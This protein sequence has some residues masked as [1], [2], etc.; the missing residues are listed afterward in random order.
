LEKTSEIMKSNHLPNTTMPAR[1][2][3]TQGCQHT[4]VDHDDSLY[5]S[6]ANFDI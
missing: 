3:Y 5:H 6:T 1:S 2:Y 4:A